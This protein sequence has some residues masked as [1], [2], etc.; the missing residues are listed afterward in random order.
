MVDQEKFW[1]VTQNTDK[2]EDVLGI[3]YFEFIKDIERLRDA[4]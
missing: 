1:K 4:Q 2:T 3:P